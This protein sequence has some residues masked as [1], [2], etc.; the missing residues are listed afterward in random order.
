MSYILMVACVVCVFSYVLCFYAFARFARVAC[1]AVQRASLSK[2]FEHISLHLLH[3]PPPSLL[4]PQ[5][6]VNLLKVTN[7]EAW[8]LS[9][10]GLG[11]PELLA[12]ANTDENKRVKAKSS[13]LRKARLQRD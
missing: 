3:R 10:R 2:C 11:S 12:R 4:G 7:R 8:G 9:Y 1:F 6:P 13:G 5:G